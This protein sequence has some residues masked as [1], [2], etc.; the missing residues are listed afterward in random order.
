M[1]RRSQEIGLPRGL[2]RKA[3]RTSVNRH[4]VVNP[5]APVELIVASPHEWITMRSDS[6]RVTLPGSETQ[7]AVRPE[8]YIPIAARMLGRW[9]PGTFIVP[10]MLGEAG[11]VMM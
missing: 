4:K 9:G 10:E 6:R 2:M 1:P 5:G 3:W 8:S 7:T 11:L